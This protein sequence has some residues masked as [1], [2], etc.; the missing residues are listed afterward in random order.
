MSL[1]E[2]DEKVLG[3]GRVL[4]NFGGRID[5]SLAIFLPGPAKR[6]RLG[7]VRLHHLGINIVEA[8]SEF[9]A[10]L[11]DIGRAAA[12]YL[13][14]QPNSGVDRDR[15]WRM[16]L[17]LVAIRDC[18]GG[19]DKHNCEKRRHRIADERNFRKEV[20]QPLAKPFGNFHAGPCRPLRHQNW[21]CRGERIE[22]PRSRRTL[23]KRQ[24]R[25]KICFENL[26][27]NSGL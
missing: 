11:I 23:S 1:A 22:E 27:K 15:Q 10:R 16:I 7:V 13:I 5:N 6:K 21:Y 12:G 17:T 26:K 3:S 19:S 25:A 4:K 9:Q 24:P 20:D 18:K 8:L 2:V 14:K